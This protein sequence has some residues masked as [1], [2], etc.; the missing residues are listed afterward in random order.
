ML[1]NTPFFHSLVPI[2]IFQFPEL[3]NPNQ[4]FPCYGPH[5][6]VKEALRR[7]VYNWVSI[8]YLIVGT[9]I[10]MSTL[11]QVDNHPTALR[12]AVTQDATVQN[13]RLLLFSNPALCEFC[14]RAIY[15]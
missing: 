7:T 12:Q 9:L 3:I 13:I 1:S 2:Q 6:H 10:L 4:S 8:I 11:P 14:E 15:S 5:L